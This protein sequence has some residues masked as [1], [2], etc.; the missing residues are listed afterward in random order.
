MDA[1]RNDSLDAALAQRYILYI[2]ALMQEELSRLAEFVGV[3]GGEIM[4]LSVLCTH[5][6][7]IGMTHKVVF[8]TVG[9]ILA[10]RNYLDA[11]RRILQNLVEQQRI[12]GAAKD[13]RVNL[14]VA[15]HEVVDALLYKIVGTGTVVFV[16]L[17]E[18]NPHWARLACNSDVGK[19]L[20]YFKNITLT[21]YGSFS[22]HNAYVAA[23]SDAA[24]TLGSRTDDA[25]H[26]AVRVELWQVVLLNGA[27]GF[28]RSRVAGQNNE[29]ATHAEKLDNSLARKLINDVE[30]AWTIRRAG[31]VAKIKIIIMGQDVAHLVQDG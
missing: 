3:L 16:V 2:Y 21:L 4:A 11:A 26:T 5:G 23:L 28:G 14:R 20:L 24:Y 19:E 31:V 17:N 15:Y 12:M 29:V 25:K 27:Q 1:G 6:L 7:D 18:R 10:L 9:H 13:D 30:R 22:C 8:K